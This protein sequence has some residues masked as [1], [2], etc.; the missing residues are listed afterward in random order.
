MPYE[1]QIPSFDETRVKLNALSE[2]RH[3]GITLDFN[4]SS[5]DL[6]TQVVKKQINA[7]ATAEDILDIIYQ[8]IYNRGKHAE[9]AIDMLNTVNTINEESESAFTQFQSNLKRE[10]YEKT[11][12]KTAKISII[13]LLVG[14]GGI[15]ASSISLL[16]GNIS[17]FFPNLLVGLSGLIPGTASLTLSENRKIKAQQRIEE[18]LSKD[19]FLEKKFFPDMQ[20]RLKEQVKTTM[21]NSP[22]QN[23]SFSFK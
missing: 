17:L 22:K 21:V 13:F 23:H 4:S 19:I 6:L 1:C 20:D 11:G 9:T 12:N 18:T 7:E 5:F 10:A 16:A 15:L 3:N 14:A 2:F 8:E